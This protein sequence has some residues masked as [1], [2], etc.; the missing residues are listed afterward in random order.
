MGLNITA[1][2]SQVQSQVAGPP[3]AVE[4]AIKDL[5]DQIEAIARIASDPADAAIMMA[6]VIAR[7]PQKALAYVEDPT[8]PG[9]RLWIETYQHTI[10]VAAALVAA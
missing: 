6:D 10:Q 9:D 4:C 1:L 3:R 8:D 2:T 5:Q 7:L